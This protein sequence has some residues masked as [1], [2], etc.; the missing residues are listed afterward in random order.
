MLSDMSAASVEAMTATRI[1]WIDNSN[2]LLRE[3]MRVLSILHRSSHTPGRAKIR[4]IYLNGLSG[5]VVRS[6][7]GRTA[8][9]VRIE[10]CV[11]R[12][13]P[14]GIRRFNRTVENSGKSLFRD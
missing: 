6:G 8:V 1:L 7:I 5:G 10:G 9:S 14:S 12:R 2:E 13:D 3:I 4:A 11:N